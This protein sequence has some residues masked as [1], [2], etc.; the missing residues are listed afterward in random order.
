MTSKN[1]ILPAALL[2]GLLSISPSQ[3]QATTLVVAPDPAIPAGAHEIYAHSQMGQ[4]FV[5]EST[6]AQV[7]FLVNYDAASAAVSAP[8]APVANLVTTIYSGEGFTATPLGE[9][10]TIVDTTTNGFVDFNLASAGITLTPGATYTLGMSIDNRGWINPS[11]CTYSVGAQPTGAY[12]LGHP[13]F[14]SQITLDETG[15][16]DNSFHVIDLAPVVPVVTPTPVPVVPVVTPTPVPIVP[17]VTPAPIVNTGKK[18]DVKGIISSVSSDSIT[19][20]GVIVRI[21]A[22]TKIE[23]NDARALKVGQKVNYKGTK[24]TDGSVTASYIEVKL[25]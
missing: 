17:V 21:T 22:T 23:L 25:S 1:L 6:Q 7:G 2:A 24:N 4:S 10:T 20:N 14:K 3:V 12:D 19:V 16:C 8:N 13:F 5:A 18:V 9:I 11:A 15:I